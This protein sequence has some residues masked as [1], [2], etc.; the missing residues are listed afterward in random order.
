M[1]EADKRMRPISFASI[2]VTYRCNAKCHMCNTWQHPSK[3]EEEIGISVYEKLPFMGTVNV[4]GGEPFLREDLDEVIKALKK[5]TNRLVI[6]SNGFFTER[7][8]RLFEKRRDIGIRISIEGLPK[9]NDDLRGIKDGFDRGLRTL[10]GLHHMGVK[11]I[12]FGITVSDRNAKDMIELYHLAKMMGI[13]FA[14]AAIHNAFYF[15]KFDNKFEHQEIAIAEFKKLIDEL[16][17]SSKVKDWFRAYFNY[18]LINYI[19]GNPRLLP[20]EMGHDSFFI[21][22]SGEIFPCNVMEESMGNLKEASFEDI[23][24]SK[25]AKEV[26]QMVKQCQQNC[27]MIGSVSQQMKKYIWKPGIWIT[28]NKFR[29]INRTVK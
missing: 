26:R 1:K 6:S 22:P 18:G 19:K 17:K 16:L 2:I 4:T 23:W 27:W 29:L 3:R 7:I 5:K 13:E 10:I 25:R 9:A 24:Y 21:D 28:K 12:G 8:L 11:D 20:C 15:H 14:T